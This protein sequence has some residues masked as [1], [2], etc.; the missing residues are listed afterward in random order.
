MAG[1]RISG[2]AEAVDVLVAGGG[3]AGM[4]AAFAAASAGAKVLVASQGGVGR[5]GAS[6]VSMSV[7]RFATGGERPGEYEHYM[8]DA[9]AGVN[10]PG[11]VAELV[12]RSP[13]IPGFVGDFIPEPSVKTRDVGGREIPYF[14][15]A[16]TKQGGMLTRAARQ[17]LLAH[18]RIAFAEGM[19][20]AHL[21]PLAGGGWLAWFVRNGELHAAA[22]AAVV[23]ATG[24]FPALYLRHS[25]T[26]ELSGGG[27]GLALRLGLTLMDM[28]FVQFYPYRIYAPR[29]CDIFPDIFEHGA[30]LLSLD[31][32]RFMDAYAKKDLENRD[33]LA[34]EIFKLGEVRLD[35]EQADRSYLARETPRLLHLWELF[36]DRPLLVRA[37]AHFSMGGVCIANDGST[38]LDGVFAAGEICGGLHGAN[39]LAGHALSET[40]VFGRNAGAAAAAYAKGRAARPPAAIIPPAWLPEPG[41][42]DA[43]PLMDTLREALWQ[44]VG[45]V[46]NASGL[47]TAAAIALRVADEADAMRPANAAEWLAVRN[48]AAVAQAVIAAA[49]LRRESRG[50]HYRDDFPAADAALCGNYYHRGGEVWFE[51]A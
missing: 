37:H 16:P 34:R 4:H 51:H 8:V 15:S 21:E 44:H 20:I 11:R 23:L 7:H 32:V 43:A 27:L 29:I 36:P 2:K 13:E 1:W 50:A 46:R 49:T 22:A 48:G 25:A 6:S 30:R 39:R 12:R 35:L 3:M 45:V 31:G 41:D 18:E 47:A 40:A 28:E 19:T 9:G 33:V 42:G 14:V 10:C 26:P 38:G 17:T 24:G 5:S